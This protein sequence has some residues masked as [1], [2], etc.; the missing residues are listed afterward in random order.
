MKLYLH[1]LTDRTFLVKPE[2]KR[3]KH[4][5]AAVELSVNP[6]DS[7]E[8]PTGKDKFKILS[9]RANQEI[10]SE[11]KVSPGPKVESQPEYLVNPKKCSCFRWSRISMPEDCPWRIYRDQVTS[12]ILLQCRLNVPMKEY[13]RRLGRAWIFWSC[14]S[15]TWIL[16]SLTCQILPISILSVYQASPF[17]GFCF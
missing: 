3:S 9:P 14:L 5:D 17:R 4:H 10:T 7:A 13:R 11:K 2:S 1:N 15:E 12:L 8:L 6:N 16:S